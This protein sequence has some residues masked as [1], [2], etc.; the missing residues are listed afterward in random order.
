MVVP[1]LS[2]DGPAG[3]EVRH[4]GASAGKPFH[5]ESCRGA[6]VL[7]ELLGEE[8][9][10]LEARIFDLEDA[11]ERTTRRLERLE[12]RLKVLG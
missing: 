8:L 9:A 12:S 10:T 4:D 11:L 1:N 2:N 3:C 7:A 5:Q 6:D